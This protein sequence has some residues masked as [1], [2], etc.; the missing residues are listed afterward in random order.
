[1]WEDQ[2]HGGVRKIKISKDKVVLQ[3]ESLPSPLK[4]VS[5]GLESAFS[6]RHRGDALINVN[7]PQRRMNSALKAEIHQLLFLRMTCVPLSIFW[8][9]LSCPHSTAMTLDLPPLR[10]AAPNDPSN[11]QVL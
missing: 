4:S 2:L 10:R 8:G 11:L 6:C 7:I 1:M 9:G 3:T 5:C